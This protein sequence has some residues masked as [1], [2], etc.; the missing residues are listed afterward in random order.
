MTAE[1][2]AS[3]LTL[4]ET[5]S[6][7]HPEELTSSIQIDGFSAYYGKNCIISGLTLDI[8]HK[9]VTCLL[10]PSGTGK[11]TLLRWLNRINE[12]TENASF[13]GRIKTL[14]LDI[15]EDYPDVTELRRQ[16]GM[17]FQQPCVFPCSVYDNMLMGLR[18]LKLSKAEARETIK[19]SL[20][21]AALWDEVAHR[22]E[23]P[24]ISLSLGQ[25]Q[26]LCIARALV[27][28]P[29]VLLLDEPTAS[30][31]PISSRAIEDLVVALGETISIVMVTHNI[32]QTKRVADHVVFMCDGKIV[33]QGSRNHMFSLRT[34][35][36]TRTYITEEFC[37]C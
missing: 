33:E 34:C 3:H 10:G 31:D 27:L 17:V 29:K 35:D 4:I 24:A 7:A 11:S 20:K 6:Q 12:E 25:Q 1:N 32:A 36:K 2:T 37:D 5:G 18:H 22:L 8:A 28:K 16:I 21:R 30:I 19:G 13:T 15:M 23:A 9:G 14:G 26:R